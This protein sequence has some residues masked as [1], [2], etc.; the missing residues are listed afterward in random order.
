M[1][2]E[3]LSKVLV[4]IITIVS[5]YKA[6]IFNIGNSQKMKADLLEKLDVAIER[7]K[8]HTSTE[9]FRLI[10]GLRMSY[11]DIESLAQSDNC[12][13]IIYA[14]KK[15]PGIVYYS[16]GKLQ[17]TAIASSTIFKFIEKFASWL[18]ITLFTLLAAMSFYMFVF[19]EGGTSIVGIVLLAFSTFMLTIYYRQRSYD[20]M[21]SDI[22]LK[23]TYQNHR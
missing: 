8:K 20:R 22:V 19:C 16:N 23:N 3:I 6:T 4:G 18:F 9:L 7:K 1:E 11:P 5:S 14:L 13:A 10:H 2:I 17:Y 21:V 12:S 15:T